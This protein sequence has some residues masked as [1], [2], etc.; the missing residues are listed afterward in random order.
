[1]NIKNYFGNNINA[2]VKLID[3]EL[4]LINGYTQEKIVFIKIPFLGQ[5][6]I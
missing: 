6:C 1:M 4:H 5:Y 3:K 2:D